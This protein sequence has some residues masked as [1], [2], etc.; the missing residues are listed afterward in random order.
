M[1]D[2]QH[3][4]LHCGSGSKRN[5]WCLECFGTQWLT[6]IKTPILDSSCS[7]IDQIIAVRIV[8][9]GTGIPDLVGPISFF[10]KLDSE[11]G[12]TSYLSKIK[13]LTKA[14]MLI[15]LTASIIERIEFSG[16]S[17]PKKKKCLSLQNCIEISSFHIVP[18]IWVLKQSYSSFWTLKG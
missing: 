15:F 6:L 10:S 8:P 4:C 17:R 16:N 7:Y 1:D 2:P 12:W 18:C 13:C 3:K 11:V 9:L 5:L 14:E